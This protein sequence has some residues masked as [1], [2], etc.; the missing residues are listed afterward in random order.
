MKKH[1]LLI[2]SMI[3]AL[4]VNGQELTVGTYNIRNNNRGDYKI[5][6]GWNQRKEAMCAEINFIYPDLLGCQEV[7]HQ[8]IVDMLAL[9]SDY[10]YLGVGREDGKEE[11]EYSPIYYKKDR[12][13]LLDSGT[14]WLAEEPTKPVMGWDAACKRVCTWGYFKDKKSKQKFYFFN[15]HMDHIGVIARREGAKL[16]MKK[17][18]ELMKTGEP[19]VLTGDFN[20]DQYNEIYTIFSESDLLKDCYANA[21]Y[22]FAPNGSFNDFNP[23]GYTDARIDHIFVS[24]DVD[25]MRYAILNETDWRAGADG[26]KARHVLSDHYP[27]FAKIIF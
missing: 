26:K 18:K 14:F 9:L 23:E 19:V 25:V 10:A 8:Q 21:K 12:F 15:T 6:S 5:F 16:I 20:V 7:T 3:A 2:L 27:V 24:K 4:A 13:K 1:F 22:R 17:M 11:G